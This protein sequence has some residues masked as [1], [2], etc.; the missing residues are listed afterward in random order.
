VK[1][2]VVGAGIVGLATARQLAIERPDSEIVVLEKEPDVA[3]HQTG[4]NSGVIHAGI[5]YPP[6]SLKAQLCRRGV[7]LLKEFCELRSVRYENV[8]KLVVALDETELDRLDE[9]H[10]RA[11]ANGVSDACLVGR[12][13]IAELEPHAAGIRAVHSPSTA[14]VDYVAVSRA[15]AADLIERGGQLSTSTTVLGMRAGRGSTVVL[16]DGGE[17]RADEVVVCA[18]LQSSRLAKASGEDED[19]LIVPF[20]GEYY[21]LPPERAELV[22]GLIYPVP[23]PRYPFLGIHLTRRIDGAVDVGPNA[24]LA[25]ALQGYRRRDLAPRDLATIFAW[26]GFR[27][28]ARQHWRT[29]I[30]EMRGSLSKRAYLAQA[31]RYLPELGL[32]DL[33]PAPSGVRAQAVGRDGQLVDDF[34]ISR[35]A[36]ITFVRNAPS[37]AATSSMA[38]AEHIVRGVLDSSATGSATPSR[39]PS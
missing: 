18:G 11:L 1:L 14:I 24:V 26:P 29:G 5:Y 23:D 16:T 22:R 21:R 33:R 8:G 34:C 12:D 25:T 4:H 39:P 19:P 15:L 28:M 13:E 38:I 9:V 30:R 32:S 36:G 6:G 37:P 31:R 27:K 35:S 17:L 7:T 10:R 20:R 3:R 2:V